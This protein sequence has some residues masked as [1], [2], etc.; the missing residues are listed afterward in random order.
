MITSDQSNAWQC[1][2]DRITDGD[3][4]KSSFWDSGDLL[5][6]IE[7]EVIIDLGKVYDL[8]QINIF[9]YYD[10]VRF[11]QYKILVSE[12]FLIGKKLLKRIIR[13]LL[14]KKEI[15]ILFH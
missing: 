2:D 1:P 8:E 7:P 10:N 5:D 15:V 4:S 3:K 6:N 13:I 12:I 9:T 14:Q 11:Y